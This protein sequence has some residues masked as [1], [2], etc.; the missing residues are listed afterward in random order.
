VRAGVLEPAAEV[1]LSER[2]EGARHERGRERA[3]MSARSFAC[4]TMFVLVVF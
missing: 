2:P 4:Q 3:S 1:L